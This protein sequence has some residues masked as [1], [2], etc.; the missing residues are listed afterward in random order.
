M[1]RMGKYDFVFI[2]REA[3]PIGPPLLE[4]IIARIHRKKIIY[5]YDDAIWIPSVSSSNKIALHFKWF[6]KVKRICRM[7]YGVSA[8][9]QYLANY[10]RRYCKN[11]F[12][13]PTVVDTEKI[14]NKKQDQQVAKPAVGWTGTI[15]T[16]K[17][18]DIVIPALQR[19]Q[20]EIDFTFI[21]IANNDP[22]PPLKNYRFISWESETEIDDLLTM[23]I[24]LMPLFNGELEKG[25]CG[26]KA[27]QYMSL[28]IPAL[29]S[30]VGVNTTIVDDGVNGIICTTE[31]DWVDKIRQLL[32]DSELRS[33]LGMAAQRKI[34]ENYSV[35]ATKQLFF[36]LF[37]T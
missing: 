24:G 1:F 10:A 36:S 16:L 14:H 29:V 9:N 11:V 15:T 7:S 21:V 17:Y 8:G 37:S 18:L 25:K 34:A 26:F 27:I 13:I 30:P 4:W 33:R 28:G 3:A 31:Q 23:H 12:V 22:Q 6:S 35:K 20:E 2:H 32:Q 19:L 5:D